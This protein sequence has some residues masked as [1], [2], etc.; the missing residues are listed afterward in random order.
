MEKRMN[1]EWKSVTSKIH[2]KKTKKKDR[3]CDDN[4]KA[5]AELYKYVRI[6]WV[7]A[8]IFSI[9]LN[10]FRSTFLLFS[11]TSRLLFNFLRFCDAHRNIKH[12][13]SFGDGIA[14]SACVFDM[15]NSI[16]YYLSRFVFVF[17]AC[18]SFT[19]VPSPLIFSFF[20]LLNVC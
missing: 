9:F 20:P 1:A 19:R 14:S 16:Y 15:S 2:K 5:L 18:A 10:F 6:Y 3:T 8:I 7:Y 13:S 4:K 11:I 12:L 17:S